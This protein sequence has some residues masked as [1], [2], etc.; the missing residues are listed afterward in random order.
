MFLVTYDRAVPTLKRPPLPWVSLSRLPESLRT[1]RVSAIEVGTLHWCTRLTVHLVHPL[2]HLPP[3]F[4]TLPFFYVRMSP[5]PPWSNF[6]P[7]SPSSRCTKESLR[8]VA[9]GRFPRHVCRLA[10][11]TCELPRTLHY[12]LRIVLCKPSKES[13]ES[14]DRERYGSCKVPPYASSAS[15]YP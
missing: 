15:S 13:T 14:V 7:G 11:G 4:V 3:P 5:T 2:V 6:V 1:F 12:Y 9:L 8:S 10:L